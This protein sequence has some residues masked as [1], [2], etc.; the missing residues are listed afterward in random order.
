MKADTVHHIIPLRDDWNR[1]NDI[2]NL[3]SLNHDTHSTIESLYRKDKEL[4]QKILK[5]MLNEYRELVR[6]GECKSLSSRS[7]P[8]CPLSSHKFL[9]T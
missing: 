8:H 3:M 4:T 5:E 7:R 1:R 6:Q 9:N 2:E